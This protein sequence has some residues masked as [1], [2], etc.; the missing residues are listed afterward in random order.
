MKVFPGDVIWASIVVDH[1][2][3]LVQIVDKTRGRRFTRRLQ[4]ASPDLST[5]EWIV[6]APASC[7]MVE[8]ATCNQSELTNFGKV[9]FSHTSRWGTG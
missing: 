4:M 9:A 6:E 2:S 8:T 3:V 1:T 7:G 5:A